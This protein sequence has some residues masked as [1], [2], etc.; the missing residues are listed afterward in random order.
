MRYKSLHNYTSKLPKLKKSS[1]FKFP[2][3]STLGSIHTGVIGGVTNE[4][5]GFIDQITCE[6]K[7]VNII[8]TGGDAK[9]LSKTL[10]IAIFANQIFILEGLNSI[11]NLNK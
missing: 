10:K 6:Y 4:I 5:L 8:L 7:S 3:D 1:N 9:F 11:L 2:A